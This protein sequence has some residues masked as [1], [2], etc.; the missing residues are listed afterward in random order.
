MNRTAEARGM[1]VPGIGQSTVLNLGCGRKHQPDAI[2]LDIV[3]DTD[4]D[5][6]HD[7]NEFPWPFDSSRFTEVRAF[8]VIE[9][10]ADVVRVMDEIHRI[11]QDGALIKITV[12]HYSC[13]NAFTDPTHRHY[14]GCNSFHY[15]TGENEFSFYTQRRYRRRRSQLVFYPT[16]VNKLVWRLANRFSQ[17]YERYWAWI[18]PAWYLY[19]ELQVIKKGAY[20]A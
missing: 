1:M 4:P 12:P 18:F 3:P 2:N 8:D 16:L 11:C 13:S 6:L 7:L 14:F 19:F 20:G 9:H 5:V 17:H 10:T 15:F